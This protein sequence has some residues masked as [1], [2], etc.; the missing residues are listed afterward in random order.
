M[1]L[2]PDIEPMCLYCRHGHALDEEHISCRKKGV[3]AVDFHCLRFRYDPLKRVPA[4]PVRI[5]RNYSESDFS[6]ED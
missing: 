2:R 1:I 5:G 6:L 3:V 4:P